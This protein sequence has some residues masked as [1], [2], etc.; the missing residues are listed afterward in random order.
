MAMEKGPNPWAAGLLS[1]LSPGLGQIYNGR[2]RRGHLLF[3]I[4]FV[5]LVIFILC[6]KFVP[7][8]ISF[9]AMVPRYYPNDVGFFLITLL[10]L[11]IIGIYVYA[12]FGAFFGALALSKG[13]AG[14]APEER[15]TA[16]GLREFLLMH[17]FFLAL[18]L[19]LIVLVT[20]SASNDIMKTHNQVPGKVL[21]SVAGVPFLTPNNY[22]R[23]GGRMD[24]P[25]SELSLHASL[26][27]LGDGGAAAMAETG[28]PRLLSIRV[29]PPALFADMQEGNL[30][31][32]Q[33]AFNLVSLFE[34]N[35]HKFDPLDRDM[36][37][38]KSWNAFVKK[39]KGR[40]GEII[41]ASQILGWDRIGTTPEKNNKSFFVIFLKGR[42]VM[43]GRCAKP[44]ENASPSC[45]AY[46]QQPGDR[47]A[48][49]LVFRSKRLPDALSI[50]KKL[51]ALLS[52][53]NKAAIDYLGRGYTY[54]SK[55][56]NKF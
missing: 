5:S 4:F 36:D 26:P 12:F 52:D 6:I 25:I 37:F 38:P 43:T 45:S 27:G 18:P 24:G 15:K 10:A 19:I 48:L 42:M 11:T 56:K 14:A 16:T 44:M 53:F 51:S 35:K 46:F 23:S 20:L 22:F 7:Y 39:N 47:L 13:K 1:L 49:Q 29:F 31:P 8:G 50:A 33:I 28:A 30:I 17:K 9:V 41:D 2:V 40:D 34:R 3:F 55:T 21:T 54:S 32:E